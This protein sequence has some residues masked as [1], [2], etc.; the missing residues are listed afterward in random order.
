MNTAAWI[1]T[2]LSAEELK[3]QVISVIENRLGRVRTAD[4]YAPRTIDLDIILF[5]EQVIDDNLW[6]RD[7]LA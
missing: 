2:P 1:S 3:T 5:D 4:K 6:T 7:F